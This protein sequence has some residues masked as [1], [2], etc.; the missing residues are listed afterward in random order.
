MTSLKSKGSFIAYSVILAVSIIIML[1][2]IHFTV[3]KGHEEM[4][5]TVAENITIMRN[6]FRK[7]ADTVMRDAGQEI[8]RLKAEKVA[9]EIENYLIHHPLVTIKSMQDDSEFK[10]IAIQP[11]GK[12]GYT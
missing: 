3:M 8:I 4:E 6:S 11:I 9:K 5:E 10:S 1:S 12:T 2:A 7:G